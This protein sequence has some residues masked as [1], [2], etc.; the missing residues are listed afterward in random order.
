MRSE[1]PSQGGSGAAQALRSHRGSGWLILVGWFVVAAVALAIA[2]LVVPPGARDAAFWGRVAWFE[3]LWAVVVGAG[4]LSFGSTGRSEDVR[5]RVG[6]VTPTLFVVAVAYAAT[7]L[8]LM[9]VHAW[10]PAGAGAD[11]VHLIAQLALFAAAAV[12]GV[13]LGVARVGSID[14]SVA[15]DAS[16]S[17]EPS[18]HE[19]HAR[20]SLLEAALP[21]GLRSTLDADVRRLRER[22]LH[23]L[24]GTATLTARSDYQDLAR[25]VRAFCEVLE[26]LGGRDEVSDAE[27]ADLSA[28]VLALTARVQGVANRAIVR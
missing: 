7:S 2:L 28:T 18:P 10:L 16:V 12:A 13:L 14:A 26:E 22:L 8:L 4:Y 6:G 5:T 1:P 11:R 25:D 27:A 21:G 15:G 24:S 19:L 17:S 20:L 9:L 23:S 3:V